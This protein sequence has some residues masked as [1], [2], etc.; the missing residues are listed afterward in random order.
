MD[1]LDTL[2]H[3]VLQYVACMT[4]S[5]RILIIVISSYVYFKNFQKTA[6][7]IFVKLCR[8]SGMVFLY[9]H[10]SFYSI[11]NKNHQHPVWNSVYT[12]REICCNKLSIDQELFLEKFDIFLIFLGCVQVK[13]QL[14]CLILYCMNCFEVMY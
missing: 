9:F 3:I 2:Q 10:C 11:Q 7:A 12:T 4:V 8:Y 1:K 13:C 6:Y 14:S 5:H